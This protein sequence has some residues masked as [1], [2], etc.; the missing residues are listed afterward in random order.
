MKADKMIFKDEKPKVK[1]MKKYSTSPFSCPYELLEIGNIYTI[2]RIKLYDYVTYFYLEEFPNE[3]FNSVLFDMDIEEN[4]EI[5]C[6]EV[7]TEYGETILCDIDI[8]IYKKY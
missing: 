5:H 7:E 1:C 3:R 2:N 8:K 4:K 6:V